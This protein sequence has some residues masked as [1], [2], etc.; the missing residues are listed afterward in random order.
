[1]DRKIIGL[2]DL[3]NIEIDKDEDLFEL[4]ANNKKDLIQIAL[5]NQLNMDLNPYVR[6]ILDNKDRLLLEYFLE[7][8]EVLLHCFL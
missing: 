6:T 8:N 7:K 5:S 1:M 4:I 3:G 2:D